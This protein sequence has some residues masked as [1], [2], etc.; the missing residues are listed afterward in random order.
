MRGASLFA[1]HCEWSGGWNSEIGVLSIGGTW[2]PK[3]MRG[4]EGVLQKNWSTRWEDGRTD[5]LKHRILHQI[6]PQRRS[7]LVPRDEMEGEESDGSENECSDRCFTN[8]RSLG[9]CLVVFDSCWH[10]LY[11]NGWLSEVG[12]YFNFHSFVASARTPHTKS[13][14][15]TVFSQSSRFLPRTIHSLHDL[16]RTWYSHMSGF[17]PN[18]LDFVTYIV[19]VS[20]LCCFCWIFKSLAMVDVVI[21]GYLQSLQTVLLRFSTPISTLI[22]LTRDQMQRN[23]QVEV[24]QAC[25]QR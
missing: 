25:G 14:P 23:M 3:K 20:V 7:S 17:R 18:Y 24:S 19:P 4:R 8:M 11:F 2:E 22:I 16:I 10:K 13:A 9:I 6:N 15:Q 5:F 12:T 21:E 1:E